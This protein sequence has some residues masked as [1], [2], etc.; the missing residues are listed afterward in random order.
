MERRKKIDSKQIAPFH[1]HSHTHSQP[2]R[3]VRIRTNQVI[4]LINAIRSD[5]QLS[6]QHTPTHRPIP[7][8]QSQ[9]KIDE[10]IRNENKREEEEKKKI[11]NHYLFQGARKIHTESTEHRHTQPHT[12]AE[13][14]IDLGF[15]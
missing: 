8:A 11:G 1:S 2:V 6:T 14:K 5:T 9:H 15:S 3:S 4:H 13:S 7:T 10:T 12:N